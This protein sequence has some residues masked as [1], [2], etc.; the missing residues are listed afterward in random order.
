MKKLPIL[1]LFTA[2][3]A[4]LSGCDL[5]KTINQFTYKSLDEYFKKNNYTESK[6]SSEFAPIMQDH[7]YFWSKTVQT[8]T[9]SDRTNDIYYSPKGDYIEFVG[10]YDQVNVR[11]RYSESFV[12]WTKSANDTL[13]RYEN[14]DGA[15]VYL[16][17]DLS[18]K[19]KDEDGYLVDMDEEHSS[20]LKVHEYQ[21]GYL[22]K[23]TKNFM[24][25]S[26]KTLQNFYINVD[27]TKTFTNYSGSIT[28]SDS[29][30]LTEGLSQAK[31]Y[32]KFVLPIPEGYSNGIYHKDYIDEDD[33]E[34]VAYDVILP[35]LDG[36]EY[37]EFIENSGLE[38]Y[39]GEYHPY[40]DA[41]NGGE[42]VF[43]DKNHE[44]VIHL[45][46]E[47]AIAVVIGKNTSGTRMR[48]QR[49][50]SKFSYFGST[51]NTLTDW[52][53]SDKQTMMNCYG[54]VLPFINLGRV[55][56]VNNYKR[57]NGE[58]PMLSALDMDVECY[59][60]FDNFYKDVIS[61]TY[62]PLLVQAGFTEYVPPE[63]IKAWKDSEDVKYA[64]CY[65]NDELDLA[66]KFSFDDIYGNMIK[67]FKKSEM[68]SW[69]N[70][71]KED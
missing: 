44:F 37:A 67:V 23:T 27:D 30:L 69:H 56:H 18:E 9:N 26:D 38:I 21:N 19:Y 31:P 8:F 6:T 15:Y 24:F 36:K 3:I 54:I 13:L 40:F 71:A 51:V 10:G 46:H 4:P 61:K 20:Y 48:I 50:E 34:W 45:E 52:S 42:W 1:L 17:K 63:D 65:I 64:E 33:D 49:A 66:V 55:Y 62:G 68:L 57:P 70:M 5:F 11:S 53:D 28:L 12:I 59:W 43:Y 16:N 58:H 29:E 41:I 60:I 7:I 47:S 14:E 2:L 22:F 35:Y 39:R 25:Y 32:S